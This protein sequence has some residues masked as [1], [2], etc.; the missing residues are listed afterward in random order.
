M[1]LQYEPNIVGPTIDF[2]NKDNLRFLV[3]K[4]L[5]AQENDIK[6]SHH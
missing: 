3:R 4:Y 2:F 5:K 6:L 1:Q